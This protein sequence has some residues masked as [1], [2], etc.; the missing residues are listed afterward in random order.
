MPFKLNNIKKEII[1]G[2]LTSAVIS[3]LIALLNTVAFYIHVTA[4]IITGLLTSILP[5]FLLYIYSYK[6]QK[7]YF[8]FSSVIPLFI[9]L[10]ILPNY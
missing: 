3:L 5:I 4:F 1:F 10:F 6:N 7:F 8:F 9:F 2:I